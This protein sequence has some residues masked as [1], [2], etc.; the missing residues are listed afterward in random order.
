MKQVHTTSSQGCPHNTK[1]D[2][3]PNYYTHRPCRLVWLPKVEGMEP[4][5]WF[6]EISLKSIQAFVQP[7]NHVKV[8]ASQGCL[9]KQTGNEQTSYSTHRPCMLLRFPRVEGME[10]V[11]WLS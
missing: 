2:E 3:S 9:H 1:G 6:I 8:T 4:V 11:S 5:S 10:P 7:T